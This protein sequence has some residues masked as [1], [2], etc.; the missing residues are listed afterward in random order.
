MQIYLRESGLNSCEN[1]TI[2]RPM[3]LS[4]YGLIK[5]LYG[6]YPILMK[7]DGKEIYTEAHVASDQVGRIYI[8]QKELKVRRIGQN[9]GAVYMAGKTP[10]ISITRLHPQLMLISAMGV[11]DMFADVMTGLEE[12]R[13]DTTKRINIVE[14]RSQQGQERL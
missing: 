5:E 4:V 3:L 2:G 7:L 8:G 6:Q 13:Q 14:Q 1:I 9:Q 12:L 11:R 10:I